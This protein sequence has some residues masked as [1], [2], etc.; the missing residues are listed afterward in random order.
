MSFENYIIGKSQLTDGTGFHPVFMPEYLKDFQKS[1]VEWS[2]KNARCGLFEDCRLGKTVQQLVWAENVV[3]QTNGRV[4]I[5]T[6]LSISEQT[7]EEADKF[8]IEA[9]RSRDGAL[10][11][12]KIVVTNYEQL[13]RFNPKDFVGCVCDESSILK[14][15]K[16][17]TK[18]QV[19]S[20]MR[21][22]KYRLL[23]TATASLMTTSN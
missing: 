5:L 18:Q 1:L 7:I 10:P 3:R 14:N 4:L 6:P 13:H 19:T 12:C 11:N 8:Q 2:V 23:C 22:M 16:G 17:H 15:V 21:K 20:F 9:E